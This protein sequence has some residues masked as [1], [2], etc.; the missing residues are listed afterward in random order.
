MVDG[1][2]FGLEYPP[3]AQGFVVV[4]VAAQFVPATAAGAA[5]PVVAGSVA[6]V[7]SGYFGPAKLAGALAHLCALMCLLERREGVVFSLGAGGNEQL[8]NG[9]PVLWYSN[10]VQGPHQSELFLP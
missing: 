3:L 1:C 10:L 9:I 5:V 6:I 7:A 2:D 8:Y 4:A